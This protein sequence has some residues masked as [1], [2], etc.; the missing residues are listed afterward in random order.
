[1][2]NKLFDSILSGVGNVAK[3]LVS[4][5]QPLG[6]LI[7]GALYDV[8]HPEMVALA[9]KK[10][11]EN[12]IKFTPT[13]TPTPEPEKVEVKQVEEPPKEQPKSENG[14]F[15]NYEPYIVNKEKVE[16]NW[17]NGIPQ[18]SPALSEIIR[19]VSPEDATR[20]A[21]LKLTESG[22]Q[23]NPNDYTGNSN[24][25]IDRGTNMINSGTFDWMW[26]Q[27]GNKKGTF[28]YRDKMIELGINSYEDMKDPV[29]NENMMNLVR[30]ILGYG[31]WYGPRDRGFK[32]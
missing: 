16:K 2:A 29:K 25:T 27:Q 23:L 19:Q 24:G 11:M 5:I 26:N 14:F 32:L 31:A 21:I 15:Y 4:P 10:P 30:G 17:P 13:M 9:N 28:P 20:S 18:P 7:G 6:D 12:S 3:K 8:T 1:M 22:Y